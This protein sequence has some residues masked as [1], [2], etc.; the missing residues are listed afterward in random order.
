M[1]VWDY[2]QTVQIQVIIPGLGQRFTLKYIEKNVLIFFPKTNRPEK[3]TLVWKNPQK[4]QIQVQIQIMIPGV[5]C[6]H[7]RGFYLEFYLGIHREK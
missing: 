7:N 6:G 1:F 2:P 5:G 3:L 4:V